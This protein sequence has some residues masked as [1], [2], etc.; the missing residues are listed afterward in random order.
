M[1]LTGL[2]APWH[3][4]SSQT[5]ARTRVPCIGRR[6]LYHCATREA[7]SSFLKEKK[8]EFPGGPVVR[9][10]PS[11]CRG[12]GWGL[13]SIPGW[14]TKIPQ[15]ERHGQENTEM[16]LTTNNSTPW[17]LMSSPIKRAKS[18]SE[19]WLISGTRVGSIQRCLEYL[20]SVGK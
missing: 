7:L 11:H 4:G 20:N 12:P 6:I 15:T 9:T 10:P 1:W 5:R 18:C 2:V 14:E 8:R 17:L 16:I 3:V 13:G 19:K